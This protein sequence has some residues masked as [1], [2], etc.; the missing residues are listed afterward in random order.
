MP[1]VLQKLTAIS[2]M[3]IKVLGLFLELSDPA[4]RE[5]EFGALVLTR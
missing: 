4:D 3:W 1:E 2:P 5:D